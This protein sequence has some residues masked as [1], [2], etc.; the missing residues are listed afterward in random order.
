MIHGTF[1]ENSATSTLN[2]NISLYEINL[3][4]S[5]I[6]KPVLCLEVKS[7]VVRKN[8]M[9]KS[10]QLVLWNY[11]DSENSTFLPNVLIC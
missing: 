5:K 4:Q 8:C 1:F 9:H 3:L 2:L 7:L 11:D 6:Y 10:N